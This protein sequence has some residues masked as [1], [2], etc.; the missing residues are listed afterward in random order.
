ME[1]GNINI[2]DIEKLIEQTVNEKIEA[3][4]K[5]EQD[6][7]LEENPGIKNGCYKCND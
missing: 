6:Q 7:Y 3:L 4:M 1:Y 2:S 5:I